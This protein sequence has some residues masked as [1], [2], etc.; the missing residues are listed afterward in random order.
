[1]DSVSTAARRNSV[2]SN[3]KWVLRPPTWGIVLEVTRSI[4]L[5]R[6]GKLM[7]SAT[8]SA[9][10]SICVM[11]RPRWCNWRGGED[12]FLYQTPSNMKGECRDV[13]QPSGRLLTGSC[14]TTAKD[15]ATYTLSFMACPRW[16]Q[17]FA[18]LNPDSSNACN[19]LS[20]A[21]PGSGLLIQ[22]DQNKKERRCKGGS[23]ADIR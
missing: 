10:V 7:G 3:S 8:A 4:L 16:E 21:L 23:R 14:R 19:P 18:R 17:P 15:S 9:I 11:G 6:S 13:R 12:L 5:A 20:A 1:M 2:R 22:P